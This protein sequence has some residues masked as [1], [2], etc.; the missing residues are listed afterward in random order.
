MSFVMT[1]RH[2]P[3]TSRIDDAR[4][5]SYTNRLLYL[6]SIRFPTAPSQS[7]HPKRI[8]FLLS[9]SRVCSALCITIH[10]ASW[11]AKL[12]QTR[13]ATTAAVSALP[14]LPDSGL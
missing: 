14:G 9:F 2:Q 1:W 12:I 4:T 6:T 3:E 13:D 11:P 8:D 10:R 5:K 7:I